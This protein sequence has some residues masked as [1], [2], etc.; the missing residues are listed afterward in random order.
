MF[1]RVLNMPMQVMIAQ[2]LMWFIRHINPG[3]IYNT[4]KIKRNSILHS[5]LWLLWNFEN[6]CVKNVLKTWNLSNFLC[7]M[8][9]FLM[10]PP[11]STVSISFSS[12]PVIWKLSF[13]ISLAS[14]L[15]FGN[16]WTLSWLLSSWLRYFCLAYEGL[17]FF[18]QHLLKMS[19]KFT[20]YSLSLLCYL[21]HCNKL[22][23]YVHIYHRRNHL[24]II[25][26]S[27]WRQRDSNP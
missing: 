24:L 15:E 9:T 6:F 16:N 23:R 1:E 20:W 27:R 3:N 14:P 26:A 17:F 8:I 4:C 5:D 13:E 22:L 19:R 11:V 7:G 25:I 12:N 2:K 10:S 21:N 18:S